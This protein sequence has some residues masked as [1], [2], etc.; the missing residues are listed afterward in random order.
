[1]TSRRMVSGF[2]SSPM[3]RPLMS[4]PPRQSSSSFKTGSTNSRASFQPRRDSRRAYAAATSHPPRAHP[5]APGRPRYG[6]PARHRAVSS[7]ICLM[8]HAREPESRS[9]SLRNT[10]PRTYQDRNRLI[11]RPCLSSSSSREAPIKYSRLFSLSPIT[12]S[13]RANSSSM[14][15]GCVNKMS[16]TLGPSLT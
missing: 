3:C 15:P 13:L 2:S 4:L 11:V 8:D 7:N 9:R 14:Y 12:Q 5:I 10:N 6:S 1:M 16:L